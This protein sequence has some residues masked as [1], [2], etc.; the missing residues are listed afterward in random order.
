MKGDGKV[1]KI[2]AR[3]RRQVHT[4]AEFGAPVFYR[5]THVQVREYARMC[6]HMRVM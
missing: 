1:T 3:S 5:G 4:M 6:V 2:A